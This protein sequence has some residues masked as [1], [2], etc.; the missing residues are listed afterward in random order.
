MSSKKIPTT[1]KI[2]PEVLKEAKIYAIQQGLTL[3]DLI[4]LALKKEIRKK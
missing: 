3:S 4:E 2:Y 1:I